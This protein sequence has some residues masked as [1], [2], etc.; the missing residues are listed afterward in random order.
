MRPTLAIVG[1]G[2]TFDSGGL[3]LKPTDGMLTMKCDMAG[4]ATVLGAM[5][6]IAQLKLPVNV[7][8]LA[9]L[10]E[11]MTGA[12]RLQARRRA[13]RPQRQDDRSA[14]HRRRRPAGAGRRARRGRRDRRGQDHRPGH[15]HRRVRRGA[16]QR[17]R[18]RDDQRSALVRRGDGRGQDAA[19]SR[20]GSCRCSPSTTSRSRAKWPT[21]R[22][23][24]T[25]AGAARSP[26]PSSSNNSSTTTPWVHLDIAGPA[27]LEKPKPWTDGGASGVFVRTLV[28]VAREWK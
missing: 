25:A 11:N 19:A 4:A 26:P 9:G 18:R 20:A 13:A 17:R 10:V 24:A 23:S 15:A 2:V 5:Q 3:S 28:E 16:G 1:K 21:S 6:A 22:T 12:S 7:V 14:Q 27:F 8:G